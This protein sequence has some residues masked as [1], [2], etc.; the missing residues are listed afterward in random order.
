ML[1][2]FHSQG[3]FKQHPAATSNDLEQS[4]NKIDLVIIRRKLFTIFH[5]ENERGLIRNR[6]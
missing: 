2:S 1:L 3:H 5:L 6:K 4:K